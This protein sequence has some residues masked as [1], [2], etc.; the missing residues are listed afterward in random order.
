[1]GAAKVH[2]IF[3]GQTAEGAPNIP[4]N[5]SSLTD[6]SIPTEMRIRTMN[7]PWPGHDDFSGACEP[8]RLKNDDDA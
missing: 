6:M 4:W 2:T 7:G 8:L 3:L 1:M 5:I